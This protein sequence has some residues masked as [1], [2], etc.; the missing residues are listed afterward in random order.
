MQNLHESFINLDKQHLQ[1]DTEDLAT[2][3]K[4]ISQVIFKISTEYY[5]NTF[6][7]FD[8]LAEI[9]IKGNIDPNNIVKILEDWKYNSL[10]FIQENKC[11]NCFDF[12][13]LCQKML[14]D[15]GIPTT[16]I[17]RFPDKNDFTKK[18]IDFV[19]YRHI[20]PLYAN[21]SKNGLKMYILEPSWKYS[22]PIAIIPGVSSVYKDW[23]SEIKYI[24]GTEFTQI[25]YNSLK[26]ISRERLFDI[27]PINIEL[28]SKLTKRWIRVPRKLQISNTKDEDIIQYVRFDPRRHIFIT[29]VNEVEKEFLP[30]SLS[31][32]QSK[33][34][35]KTIEQPG[36]LEYLSKIFNYIKVLPSDFW[37][38]I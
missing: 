27:H 16:I 37:I 17:G 33:L 4:K 25:A 36:L 24:K 12:A 2:Q 28:C 8:K 21:E 19:K 6:S 5:F 9:S 35:E 1:I 23:N 18:Q 34:L 31:F 10:E 20:T 26:N 7:H 3:L 15:V 22:K 13:I 29:N 38:S 11:G 14:L 30:S 32:E